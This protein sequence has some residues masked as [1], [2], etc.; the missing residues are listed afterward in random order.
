MINARVLGQRLCARFGTLH[1]AAQLMRVYVVFLAY[2]FLVTDTEARGRTFSVVVDALVA[3]VVLLNTLG[4]FANLPTSAGAQP[5]DTQTS[6]ITPASLKRT[7][8]F[9]ITTECSSLFQ[10][11]HTFVMAQ[12]TIPA[13]DRDVHASARIGVCTNVTHFAVLYPVF[14][15]LHVSA[16]HRSCASEGNSNS[17]R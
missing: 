16:V 13:A 7:G 3:L 14:H 6:K 12:S 1:L 15:D 5:I 17:N 2:L 11:A 4:K 10:L 8:G 9:N